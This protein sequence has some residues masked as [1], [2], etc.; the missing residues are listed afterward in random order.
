MLLVGECLG[1]HYSTTSECFSFLFPPFFLT[2]NE[3]YATEIFQ[4]Q[5]Q[6]THIVFP[7]SFCN[8]AKNGMPQNS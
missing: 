4:Y 6:L 1:L 7:V 3:G 5:K 8:T 2:L